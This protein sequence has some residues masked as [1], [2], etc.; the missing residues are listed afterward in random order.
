MP[1]KSGFDTLVFDYT[2][3]S[4]DNDAFYAMLDFEIQFGSKK[5]H[6]LQ[7]GDE[8]SEMLLPNE[9]RDSSFA[10]SI[11]KGVNQIILNIKDST[12]KKILCVI[13]IDLTTYKTKC[14][15]CYGSLMPE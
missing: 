10:T 13:P 12:T 2:I 14:Q 7:S 8:F 6:V 3:Q 15:T 11:G 9:K 1:A 5:Y 4:K